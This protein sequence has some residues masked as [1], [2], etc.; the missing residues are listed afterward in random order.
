MNFSYFYDAIQLTSINHSRKNL[1]FFTLSHICDAFKRTNTW[2][3]EYSYSSLSTNFYAVIFYAWIGIRIQCINKL[4]DNGYFDNKELL[5]HRGNNAGITYAV[6]IMWMKRVTCYIKRCSSS[7]ELP[8]LNG[9][10]REKLTAFE[11]SIGCLWSIHICNNINFC[12]LFTFQITFIV[13]ALHVA[14]RKA[15]SDY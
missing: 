12:S 6:G 4:V 13:Q 8:C 1:R 5:R 10:Q 11:I 14:T 7:S 15:H 2:N 3:S 9:N